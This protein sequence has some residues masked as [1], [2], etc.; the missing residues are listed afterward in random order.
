MEILFLYS[1]PLFKKQT[2]DTVPIFNNS[3]SANF[4]N[5]I[6]LRIFTL[7]HVQYCKQIQDFRLLKNQYQQN[8]TGT[9]TRCITYK[10]F[11]TVY[12]KREER[13]REREKEVKRLPFRQKVRATNKGNCCIK[14]HPQ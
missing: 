14:N 13:E 11:A 1:S 7:P 4:K 3:V 9:Y 5:R 2:K 8:V 12:T 10:K 6:R